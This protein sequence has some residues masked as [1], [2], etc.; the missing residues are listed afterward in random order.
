M[1]KNLKGIIVVTS[2]GIVFYYTYKHFVKKGI[3][4][5]AKSIVDDNF[6]LLQK[7]SGISANTQGVVVI[8]FNDKKNK[9]QFY[10]NNRVVIFDTKKNPPVVV[11]KGTYSMGGYNISIDGGKEITNTSSIYAL[12]NEAIK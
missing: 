10:S 1:D 3:F 12:L 2:L 8:P 6:E 9:A 4:Q 11:K 7:Q 5:K